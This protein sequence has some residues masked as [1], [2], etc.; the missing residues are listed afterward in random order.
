MAAFEALG[1]FIFTFANPDA[2]G[3]HLTDDGTIVV[4]DPSDL[5]DE[6]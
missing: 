2:T 5:L 6:K 1:G 4:A 3:L